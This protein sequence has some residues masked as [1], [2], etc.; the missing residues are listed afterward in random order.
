MDDAGLIVRFGAAMAALGPFERA[1]RL[2]AGVSGG[3]DSMALALL[4]DAWARERGGSLLALVVDHGLRAESAV[5]AKLT[6]SN[7]AARGIAARLLTITDLIKGAAI[8]VRAREARY[9]VLTDACGRDGILHLLLGHHAADQAETVMMRILSGSGGRGL[10]GMPVLTETG[11]LRILRPLLAEQPSSLRAYLLRKYVSWVEDPSNRDPSALRARLRRLRDNHGAEA[12]DTRCLVDAATAAGQRR[13]ANDVIMA[14][15]LAEGATVRPEGFALLSQ[16]RIRPEALA[17]LMRMIAGAVFSPRMDQVAAI[18]PELK[19]RTIWGVR[20]LAAGRLGEG[21]LVVREEAAVE[22]P[23]PA[24]DG[25]LWDGRFRLHTSN[26]LPA[27]TLIG[28]LGAAAAR[29]RQHTDLPAAVLRVMPALW[30][31]N[32]LVAVPHLLYPDAM[33]CE[34]GYRLVFNPPRPLTSAPFLPA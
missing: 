28:A 11:S 27:G 34:G 8:A 13:A 2:A 31:R 14:H 30:R 1:P 29:V 3:A 23:V 7:L 20:I 17:E 18:A 21:W 15:A 12:D 26:P 10:A 4:A 32:I 9:R 6:V 5:E 24:I 19:P 25:A 33:A 22:P 16:G